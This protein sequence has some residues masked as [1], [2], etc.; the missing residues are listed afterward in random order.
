MGLVCLAIMAKFLSIIRFQ[1]PIHPSDQLPLQLG[2][3]FEMFR[4]GCVPHWRRMCSDLISTGSSTKLEEAGKRTSVD[5]LL[6]EELPPPPW[7][8]LPPLEAIA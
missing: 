6:V 3:P 7:L 2:Y 5:P 4:Q 1:S 8:A